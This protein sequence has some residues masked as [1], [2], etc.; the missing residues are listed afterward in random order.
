MKRMMNRWLALLVLVAGLPAMPGC[1][2]SGNAPEAFRP[3]SRFGCPDLVGD[4][5]IGDAYE[6]ATWMPHDGVRGVEDWYSLSIEPDVASGGLRKVLRRKP[7]QVLEE[8]EALRERSPAD[9]ELWREQVRYAMRSTPGA[10]GQRY[11]EGILRAHGPAVEVSQPLGRPADCDGGWTAG[12]GST[13]RLS[14]GP[15]G[16]LLMR[17]ERFRQVD[18]G[19]SFFGTPFSYPRSDGTRW[20][21]LMPLLQGTTVRIDPTALPAAPAP[22]ERDASPAPDPALASRQLA[23]EADAFLRAVKP[24]GVTITLLRA[25]QFNPS[26]RELGAGAVRMEIAG[27]F[28]AHLDPDPLQQLLR[29]IKRVDQIELRQRSARGEQRAYAL[30]RF[31]WRAAETA[32]R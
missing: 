31:T 10:P 15:E 16:E 17:V 3:A 30:V 24:R 25:T 26:A 27:T 18:T 32:R 28:D 1:D 14:R 12:G 23:A 13:P 20:Y 5:R 19:W 9:Y 4:Y 22:D 29:G 6:A 2:G 11:G 8:A 7:S 21:R